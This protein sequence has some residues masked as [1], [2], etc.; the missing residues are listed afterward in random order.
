MGLQSWSPPPLDFIISRS[1]SILADWR[2]RRG[3]GAQTFILGAIDPR[4]ASC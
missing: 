3:G 1:A 2:R 4:P